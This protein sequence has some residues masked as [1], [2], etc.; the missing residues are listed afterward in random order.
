MADEEQGAATPLERVVSELVSLMKHSSIGRS[1]YFETLLESYS[2]Y[3]IV[4]FLA[5]KSETG[6]SVVEMVQD[7]RTC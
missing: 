6:N 5:R 7:G 4:R 1:R 3:S 2:G